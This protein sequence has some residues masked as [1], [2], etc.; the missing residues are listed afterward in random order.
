MTIKELKKRRAESPNIPTDEEGNLL[1]KNTNKISG[2]ECRKKHHNGH[3]HQKP[4]P[5]RPDE[6]LG[7]YIQYNFGAE[8]PP[9]KQQDTPVT[10]VTDSTEYT[11]VTE[12]VEPTELTEQTES[13]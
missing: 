11:T 3:F 1:L 13:E 6:K 9:E 4:H 8:L 5:E 7:T 12:T 10:E 2:K